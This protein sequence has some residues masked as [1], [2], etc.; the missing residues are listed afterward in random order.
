M[1]SVM[2]AYTKLIFFT[3]PRAVMSCAGRH[4]PHLSPSGS[5][6]ARGEGPWQL[7]NRLLH[8]QLGLDGL[9]NGSVEMVWTAVVRMGILI[10]V[11]IVSASCA[12]STQSADLPDVTSTDVVESSTTDMS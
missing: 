8:G 1:A 7:G 6:V 4:I 12:S 3:G 9:A 11:V 10:G 5:L 2:T